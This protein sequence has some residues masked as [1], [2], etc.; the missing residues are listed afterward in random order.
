MGNITRKWFLAVL[1]LLLSISCSAPLRGQD[2]GSTR[3]NLGG[4]VFDKTEAV[5]AGAN[6]TIT[7]PIGS[8]TKP[9]NDQGDFLF[10]TLIPGFYS[11]KVEKTGFKIA[12]VTNLEVLINKTTNIRVTIE[13]G[14]VTE[15]VEV[16]AT[17]IS[18]ENTSAAVTADLADTTYKNLP[19]GRGVASVFY[20]SPG[21]VSGLGTG[22]ANPSISGATGLENLYVADGITM[23]DPAF[24]GLGVFSRVYGPLGSGINLSF[25]KEVQ[26]KT[27]GFEPQ[28]GHSTGGI[29]QIV[30]KSGGTETHGVIGGFFQA[31]RMSSVFKNDDDFGPTNLV[32]RELHQGSYE[33]DFELGGYV[34]GNKLKNHLF[35]FGTFNPTWNTEQVAPALGSGLFTVSGGEV[36]RK[37]TIYDYAAKLT[38]KVNDRNSIESTVSGDPAHTNTVP[39]N[40]LNIDNTSANSKWELGSRNWAVRY[41]GTFG[42]DWLV[43]AAFTYNWN[44]FD[45][46]PGSPDLY[47]ITDFTQTGGLTTPVTQRGSFRAEGLGLYEPYDSTSKGVEFDTAKGYNFGGKHTF[48]IGYTYSRP[49]YDDITNRSGPRFVIP[50]TNATGGAYLSSAQAPAAGQMDNATF[51]LNIAKSSCTLCPLMNVPDLGMVPVY[52]KQTRGTYSTPT[53]HSTGRYHAG[54]V[55]DSWEMGRHATLNLGLRWEE[56]RLTGN[57]FTNVLN[58]QW[59]PRISFVVDPKGDRK[60]KIYASFG[61][62]AYVLP[63]DL[64]LRSLSDEQDLYNLRFAP[65]SSGGVVTLNSLGTV[66]PI[67]DAA[68]LLN[69]ATGG[70]SNGASNSAQGTPL[71]PGTKME[72]NDEFVVGAEHEFRG[73]I[74]AS[75][76]YID[77]RLKRIIEDFGGVSIEAADAGQGLFYGIGNV[78]AASDFSINAN[79]IVFS[80]GAVASSLPAACIDKNGQ[81]TPFSVLNETDTFG[82]IQGSACFPAVNMNPW[83]TFNSKCTAGNPPTCPTGQS[84]WLVNP[85]ALFGGEVGSD[86]KPDGFNDPKREYQAI[87][88]E[89]NKPLSH[90]WAILANWRIA[91]LQG[92]Y[93][94]A[95]RNDNGQSD[96]GISS[97][98][99]FTPGLLGLLGGQQSIGILNS[100]RKHVLNVYTTYVLDRSVMKGLVLGS[101]VRV[102]TGVPLTTIAAQ[103][104]YVN[105][106]EVPVF[107]RGD[108]GRA[109]VTGTVDAHVEYPWKLRMSET[110]TLKFGIDLFNIANTKRSLLVNQFVDLQ[111]GVPS[112]DFK[113]PG[114]GTTHGYP[115]DLVGGFVA[116]FS[117]RASVSFNF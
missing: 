58:D 38:L 82:T 71:L 53:T 26:V 114:N 116:P 103:D 106:G 100:D 54:F 4:T 84:P 101:G 104:N 11:V 60:S 77:R 62:Y 28:Y 92:N 25:V 90:N 31:P 12:N 40:T 95:Y 81:S 13:P 24:G 56:Q 49:A 108:L 57:Q 48:S 74:V 3:G 88:F 66:T 87:E 63:L 99:D 91:R 10:P 2:Q 68:H 51:S 72:Y 1:F 117:A 43:N 89:V 113:K 85:A 36:D 111:F 86:G 7:G 102:Q 14:T 76:R 39:F 21:V 6:V 8:L 23:N 47:Q 41:N 94:G 65:E 75:A 29:V 61:R 64:A 18:V 5:V 67:L 19:L 97:L 30:T 73:G 37:T 42:A 16:V 35:Y 9:T 115:S 70:I 109:P 83:T 79:E 32:G 44:H 15:T 80:K 107:G 46:T 59:S 110:K 98:F 20:L 96:P 78:N 33:G 50:A 34:P 112:T 45:E 17:A 27:A 105:S 52:L 93:E 55:E 22:A 69:K